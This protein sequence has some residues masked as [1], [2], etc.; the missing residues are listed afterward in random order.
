[1][2]E[3][4]KVEI[5]GQA[6]PLEVTLEWKTAGAIDS[7]EK[8]IANLQ[9]TLKDAWAQTSAGM[10]PNVLAE[11]VSNA[12]TT[13]MQTVLAELQDATTPPPIDTQALT[14]AIREGLPAEIAVALDQPTLNT[15]E[16]AN[17]LSK[18]IKTTANAK[19]WNHSVVKTKEPPTEELLDKAGMKG[20]ELINVIYDP[21]EGMWVSFLKK[22]VMG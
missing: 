4:A 14:D 17:A 18:A 11:A 15:K 3:T 21:A 7:I 12:V 5:A 1:M 8:T 20:Y 16:L 13:T 2:A 22:L 9:T 6:K 19:K 10:D